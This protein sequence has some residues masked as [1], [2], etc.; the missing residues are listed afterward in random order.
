MLPSVYS[1]NDVGWSADYCGAGRLQ[2]H[3]TERPATSN[4]EGSWQLFNGPRRRCYPARSNCCA[5]RKISR[6][7]I[8]LRF[9]P[10]TTD[11]QTVGACCHCQCHCRC[12]TTRQCQWRAYCRRSFDFCLC[13]SILSSNLKTH[14]Y[15]AAFV[16]PTC[17]I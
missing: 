4:R 13:F 6:V 3:K 12:D 14:L 10:V 8:T 16:K 15:K 11:K 9:E 1:H 7:T 5:D 17:R 2:T